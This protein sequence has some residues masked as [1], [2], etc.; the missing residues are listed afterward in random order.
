MINQF[1]GGIVFY[2]QA[3]Q[4]TVFSPANPFSN[5]PIT[6]GTYLPSEGTDPTNR[7]SR[8]TSF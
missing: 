4:Y 6:W 7:R 1:N 3:Y 2:D 5:T 8:K